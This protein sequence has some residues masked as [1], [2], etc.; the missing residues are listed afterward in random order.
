MIMPSERPNLERSFE[1][2][3]ARRVNALT[4]PSRANFPGSAETRTFLPPP[5]VLP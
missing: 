4:R 2:N 1:G 5:P 3:A